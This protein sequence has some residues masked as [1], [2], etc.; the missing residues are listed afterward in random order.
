MP[1]R[2]GG[3][4]IAALIAIWNWFTLN[5]PFLLG[6]LMAGLTGTLREKR[7]GRNWKLA[8]SE[9]IMCACFAMAAI[10]GLETCGV[11]P[12]W[13]EFCGVAV[14]FL[15]TKFISDFIGDSL[16]YLRT[17]FWGQKP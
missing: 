14:G 7:E 3:A 8:F 1:D 2:N 12:A 17:R 10:K 6:G 15:G 16:A 13:S 5:I 9:G 4:F 11:S